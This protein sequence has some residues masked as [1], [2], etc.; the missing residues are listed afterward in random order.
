[1]LARGNLRLVKAQ[2]RS[3]LAD[4]VQRAFRAMYGKMEPGRI[5]D[6]MEKA[7]EKIVEHDRERGRK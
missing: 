1:M 4:T 7:C 6:V 3:D 5:T 2:D